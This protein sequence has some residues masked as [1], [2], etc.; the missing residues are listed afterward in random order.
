[1][2]EILRSKIHRATVTGT[3][4]N[5]PGSMAIDGDLLDKADIAEH[6]K[7]LV[8]NIDSGNRFETYV[9]SAPRGSGIACVMGAAAR[10]AQPGD[11][12]IVMSFGLYTDDELKQVNSRVVL[13]DDQNQFAGM[14]GDD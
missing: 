10:L 7:V 13:V 9:T 5:Y 14:L 3:E 1:M 2:R 6:E 8:V 11:K 4:L 12:V